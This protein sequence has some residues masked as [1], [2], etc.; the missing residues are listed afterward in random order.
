MAHIQ[1]RFFDSGWEA[2][3]QLS[4][5]RFRIWRALMSG[6]ALF[7]ISR[8]AWSQPLVLT[9]SSVEF[10]AIGKPAMLKIHGHSDKLESSLLVDQQKLTGELRLP[11]SSLDSGLELRDEHMKNK[12][13]EV[14]KSPY[15]VLKIDSLELPKDLDKLVLSKEKIKFKGILN[16]HQVSRDVE[17]DLSLAQLKRAPA[18]L[19]EKSGFESCEVVAQFSLALSDFNIEIPSYMGIKVADRVDIEVKLALDGKGN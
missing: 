19:S 10:V 13:L 3:K 18:G 4:K 1:S 8:S 14:Q 9:Q 12:Y 6:L 5:N 17:G 15:A 16:L 7:M 11:L 2:R